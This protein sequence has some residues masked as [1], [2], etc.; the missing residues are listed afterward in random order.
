MY[1]FSLI[2]NGSLKNAVSVS[3][4]DF[5]QSLEELT[6]VLLELAELPEMG[7]NR[8]ER[9]EVLESLRRDRQYVVSEFQVLI[10]EPKVASVA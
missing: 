8:L 7:S 6:D 4:A 10:T 5:D 1:L 2:E 9:T 3:E